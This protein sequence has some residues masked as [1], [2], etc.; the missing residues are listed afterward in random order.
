MSQRF[1][2]N[3]ELEQALRNLLSDKYYHSASGFSDPKD[4]E[5]AMLHAT[6]KI[7]ETL[8]KTKADQRFHDLVDV[9]LNALESELRN[10][11]IHNNDWKII[12]QLLQ[13]ISTLLGYDWNEGKQYRKLKYH[14]TP[15][16]QRKSSAKQTSSQ[17]VSM[18]T[19]QATT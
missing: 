18:P 17:S 19:T 10:L 9:E 15:T 8:D 4:V 7:R 11:R 13:L 14:Q 2:Y 3:L 12:A 16:Q 5:K 6:K 1:Y